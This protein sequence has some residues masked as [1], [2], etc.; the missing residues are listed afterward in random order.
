MKNLP[1]PSSANYFQK[2]QLNT[3]ASEWA[4]WRTVFTSETEAMH[5]CYHTALESLAKQAEGRSDWRWKD[6]EFGGSPTDPHGIN[7]INGASK[8]MNF[9]PSESEIEW[10][11]TADYVNTRNEK[12]K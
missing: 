4:R 3:K 1:K 10:L 5:F 6:F 12:L 2:K 7:S 8:P 11:R 9:L